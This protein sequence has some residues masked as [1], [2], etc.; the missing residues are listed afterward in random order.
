MKNLFFYLAIIIMMFAA[1][2]CQDARHAKNY[3][4][5]TLADDEAINFIRQGLESGLTEIKAA[6]VA[7]TQSTNP[8]VIRFADMIITDHTQAG[9][10]L[11][12]IETDK[13]VDQRDAINAEHE[14][15]ITGLAT[16]SGPEFD[17]AYIQ[18]MLKD[19]EE[20][21]ELFKSVGNNTSGMI[22]KFAAQTLPK[23]Q[24]HL[25]SAK[26]ISASLK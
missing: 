20:A 18:M 13:L 5:K 10:E 3:N 15:M 26:A 17:K 25:D 7:K 23:L 12:K 2:A 1:P 9:N 8:R 14:E 6:G 11:R 22:Q 19:H 21:I 24:M 4:D 16:K